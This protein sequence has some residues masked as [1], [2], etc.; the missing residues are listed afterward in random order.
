MR[1]AQGKLTIRRAVITDLDLA[2]PL[3]DAY[4]QF[5]RKPADAVLA[6]RFLL[7]RLQNRDSVILL[8]SDSTGSAMGFTQLYPSFS[9]VSAARI[10]ILND[11]F[12]VPKA[13]RSGLGRQLLS[14]AK[15]FGQKEGAVGLTL[16]TEVTNEAAQG[17]YE[18]EGWVRQRDFY[19][20]QLALD[21]E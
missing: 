7:E 17:L 20:Y 1:R 4:R 9:S 19:T 11:L 13:R 3:F 14:A 15:D 6:R 12:V 2:V 21:H 16:S 5:Y 8:A 18:S 10:F